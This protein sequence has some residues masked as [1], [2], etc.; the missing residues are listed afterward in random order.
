MDLF[1]RCLLG[2][3]NFH[4]VPTTESHDF[5]NAGEIYV[6]PLFFLYI[7]HFDMTGSYTINILLCYGDLKGTR[8]YISYFGKIL[9]GTFPIYREVCYGGWKVI[10]KYREL[11]FLFC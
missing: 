5:N 6:V 1:V 7:L 3:H 8:R 11:T 2:Y 9:G 10:M 4:N